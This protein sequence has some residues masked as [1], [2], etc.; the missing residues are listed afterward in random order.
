MPGP[1]EK[2]TNVTVKET[3][4]QPI[5]EVQQQGDQVVVRIEGAI[6]RSMSLDFVKRVHAARRMGAVIWLDLSGVRKMDAIGAAA[7]EVACTRLRAGGGQVRLHGVSEV[8]ASA[9]R[10]LPAISEDGTKARKKG[11]F[12]ALGAG[13]LDWLAAAGSLTQ[14]LGE[15]LARGVLDPLRGKLPAMGLTA[16]EAVR[17]GVDAFPVVALI[18]LLLGLILGFQ[19]AHQLRQFG[20]NIFVAN[21][22]GLGMVREF[23]PLMTAII[24]AGRSGSSITAELGTMVVREEVDALRTMGI[25]PVRYLVVPK[26]Y[27]ITVTGPALAIFSMAIG[28]VGGFFIAITFLDLAPGAYWSQIQSALGLNDFGHGVAKSLV[29]SWIV[30]LV[31]TYYGLHISGGAVGV[32]RSTTSSVVTSIFLIIFAD[33]IFTTAS[34]AM[35]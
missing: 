21:L 32:G 16:R 22:V 12:E 25:D 31:A 33:S 13:A 26:I 24:L 14:L 27:A 28:V 8:A 11:L 2:A 30:V 35:G 20:A 15:V 18:G 7:L 10:S 23:G 3:A 4:P 34:T 6:D 9:M 19:A 17:I 5:V 29:F 1:I